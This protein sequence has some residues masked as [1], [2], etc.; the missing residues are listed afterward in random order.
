MSSASGVVSW[1]DGKQFLG[2][3]QNGHEVVW[4]KECTVSSTLFI[5]LTNLALIKFLDLEGGTLFEVGTSS[6][7]VDY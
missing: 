2:V 5:W 3:R 7:L 6:L 1:S 4:G